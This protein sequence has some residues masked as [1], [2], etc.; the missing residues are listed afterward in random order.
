MATVLEKGQDG[1]HKLQIPVSDCISAGTI[2]LRL[3]ALDSESLS[4]RCPSG[5]N[6]QHHWCRIF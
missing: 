1:D 6:Q 4:V 3:P 2:A 5:K